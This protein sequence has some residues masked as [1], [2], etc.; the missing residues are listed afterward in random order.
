MKKLLLILL[1][2]LTLFANT[3]FC[4]LDVYFGNGVWNDENDAI[5]SSSDMLLSFCQLLN[6][7]SL[8]CILY[9]I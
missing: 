6:T 4:M 7:I 1:F 5:K 8:R 9:S 2:N 3:N